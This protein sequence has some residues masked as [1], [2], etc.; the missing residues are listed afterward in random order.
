MRR[1][2]SGDEGYNGHSRQGNSRDCELQKALDEI[3]EIKTGIKAE[4]GVSEGRGTYKSR[5]GSD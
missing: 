4:H 2:L 3:K 1:S 5:S